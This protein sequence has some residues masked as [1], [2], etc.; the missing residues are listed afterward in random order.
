MFEPHGDGILEIDLGPL[1]LATLISLKI[2]RIQFER[3]SIDRL[4]RSK[5]GS[6]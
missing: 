5:K 1:D 2:L 3:N 6:I 4:L